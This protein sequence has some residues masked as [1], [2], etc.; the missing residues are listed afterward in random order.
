MVLGHFFESSSARPLRTRLP[1]EEV[2]PGGVVAVKLI[3]NRIHQRRYDRG[4]DGRSGMN[5]SD[6]L[7]SK[8]DE[9]GRVAEAVAEVGLQALF[10]DVNHRCGSTVGGLTAE[11]PRRDNWTSLS[12]YRLG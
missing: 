7:R 4:E 6:V 3:V 2:S 11:Q 12:N 9:F 8:S 1:R 10:V 5:R